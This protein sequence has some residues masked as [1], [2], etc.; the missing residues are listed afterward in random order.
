VSGGCNFI[1]LSI[2]RGAGREYEISST[3]SLIAK[4]RYS[5]GMIDLDSIVLFTQNTGL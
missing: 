1:D 3:V 2:D 4:I 5:M